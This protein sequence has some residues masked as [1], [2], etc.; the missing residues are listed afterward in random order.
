MSHTHPIHTSATY[1]GWIAGFIVFLAL[2]LVTLVDFRR[3]FL[4]ADYRVRT[5][6]FVLT[7]WHLLML[8]IGIVGML[9]SHRASQRLEAHLANTSQYLK[10][11][12]FVIL[13]LLVADL[14]MYRG[15]PAARSI[16]SHRINLDWLQA[17][18]VTAWWKP[19]AQ[20]T[21]YL[22][23]VWHATMVG[24]LIAGLALTILPAVLDSY[25]RRSGFIGT[26]FG[27]LLALPQPFCSCCSSVMAPSLV[28]R[29]AS[30]NFILSFVIGSPMLNVTTIVLA[31][32][33]LPLP[34]A[35]TRIGAGI[36]LALFATY[37]VARIAERW[38]GGGSVP[39]RSTRRAGLIERAERAYL[40]LLDADSITGRRTVDTPS[41]LISTWLYSSGRIALVVVPTL[42]VW[43]AIASAMFQALPSTFGNNLAS[44]V[45]AAIGG[46]FFMISTW[47]EIPMAL[48]LIQSGSFGPAA[49]LLVVLPAIS[50]PCMMLLGGSL[51]RFRIVALLSVAVMIVGV[52]AGSMFL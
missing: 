40:G 46:T 43:S 14:F 39:S 42:W 30:T 29:G 20:A 28:R 34:F 45:L 4:F 3:G 31:L 41:Q 37:L 36:I 6:F 9:V 5:L 11:L 33:L 12:T 18:G 21:S 15:V 26:L 23:N 8:A 10:V 35:F 19:I 32:A 7:P 16:T 49:A 2:T 27:A 13:A 22:L 1:R 52:L 51:Q 48:A 38:G 50:L 44:V 47:S 24:I 17:F 25:M